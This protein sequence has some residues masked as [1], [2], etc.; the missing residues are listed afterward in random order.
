M[1]FDSLS[2]QWQGWN[3]EKRLGVK[4]SISGGNGLEV[5]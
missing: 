3:I 4:S 5:D 2:R 1:N